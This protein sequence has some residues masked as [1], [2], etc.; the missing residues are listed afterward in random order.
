[1]HKD[2]PTHR[3]V[4]TT[5]CSSVSPSQW[6]SHRS[7]CKPY[8]HI[9]KNDPSSQILTN[10]NVVGVGY[11]ANSKLLSCIW[12]VQISHTQDN[13]T[14]GQSRNRQHQSVEQTTSIK[15][16]H[17]LQSLQFLQSSVNLLQCILSKTL[18]LYF[19][20]CPICTINLST[21][22]QINQSKKKK[23]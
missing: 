7:I 3:K 14:L 10:H 21:L 5:R 2:F 19:S 8:F 12:V 9:W 4:P 18:I 11:E 13:W 22:W 23:F 17:L 15:S 6:S 20:F 1:M 16:P